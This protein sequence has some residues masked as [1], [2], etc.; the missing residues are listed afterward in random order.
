M[1]REEKV[2]SKKFAHQKVTEK[3]RLTDGRLINT[4]SR[5]VM[6]V[7]KVMVVVDGGIDG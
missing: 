3:K 1:L 4:Q 6:K 2:L 7:M 5:D